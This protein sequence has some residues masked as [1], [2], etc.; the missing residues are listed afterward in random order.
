MPLPIRTSGVPR[1]TTDGSVICW[2][3]TPPI[4]T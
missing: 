3:L 1:I 2:A 4:E